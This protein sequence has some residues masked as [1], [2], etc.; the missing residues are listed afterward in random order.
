M[1]FRLARM[2]CK[3]FDP[4]MESS[5]IDGYVADGS[6]K[7][8]GSG[9]PWEAEGTGA[10]LRD[11]FQSLGH[12]VVIL[13]P[14]QRIIA[15]N[16]ATEA[17]TGR[18]LDSLIGL[19]CYE[20]FHHDC[21]ADRNCPFPRM[22]ESRRT[23]TA[24][25]VAEKLGTTF[26]ISCTPVYDDQG[27]LLRV[28]HLAVD[29]T[30]QKEAEQRIRD[31]E[32][33]AGRAE[34][35]AGLNVL[36]SGIAHDFNNLLMVVLGNAEFALMDMPVASAAR[37]CVEAIQTEAR[38]A[39]QLCKYLLSY[40]GKGKFVTSVN[41]SE[42]IW[43]MQHLLKVL[44]SKQCQIEY[45]LRPDL[46][47]IE[48]DAAQLRQ[49]VMDVLSNAARVLQGDLA[50]LSV[51]TGRMECD[52]AYL[53]DRYF[54]ERLAPGAYVFLEVSQG[55][56]V[57]GDPRRPRGRA[58]RPAREALPENLDITTTLR[59]IHEHG[60]ALKV[61]RDRSGYGV[62]K[63][64]F[65]VS[66]EQAQPQAVPPAAADAS[67]Q[68]SG[69]ILLVDD[70]DSLRRVAK[71]MLESMG[72]TVLT[73]ADGWEAVDVFKRHAGEIDVTLLDLS[74]PGLSGQD[75]FEQIL[76]VRSDAQVLLSSGYS[77]EDVIASFDTKKPAGFIQKPY[78]QEVLQ[79]TLEA[80]L[81]M[82]DK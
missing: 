4:A 40:S 33:E 59:I 20:V 21:K 76:D 16:P 5:M 27:K 81:P 52:S 9:D 12:S 41:L 60:G 47:L 65:P 36:A 6:G 79:Q 51:V 7:G 30:R 70:D 69:T 73:A 31:L 1:L 25:V 78:E 75:V 74:M 44:T 28:V 48:G 22:C 55:D 64:I 14:E 19:P 82:V 61:F 58:P 71:R 49:V 29:I 15:A 38:K 54:G 80:L 2:A 8:E 18:P 50:K 35:L 63:I 13:D 57:V 53:H 26:L 66:E 34:H 10:S 56:A 39:A 46:P 42:V 62:Y 11:A 17:L 67:W 77:R 68:A 24:D 45:D 37:E 23:E 43:D 32:Q 72:L 3:V